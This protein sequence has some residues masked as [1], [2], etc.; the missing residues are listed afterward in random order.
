MNMKHESI[1]DIPLIIEFCKQI[2]LPTLLDNLFPA[3]GNKEGLSDSQLIVGCIA[4]MLTENNHCKSPVQ[5]W[6]KTHKITLEALLGCEIK[7]NDFEDNKLGRFIEKISND[8]LWH[9][10]EKD[11][12]QNSFCVLELDTTAPAE[13]KE[14]PAAEN[15]ISRIIK[16]D[17]TTV[18]GH[19]EIFEDGIMQRGWSKDHRPDLPQ[20]KIMVAV[21]GKTGFQIASDIVPGNENDDPLYLPVLERTRTIVN[22]TNNL[23]CGDCKMSALYIR[24][25]IAKNNE[26]YLTPLQMSNAKIRSEFKDLVNEIVDGNQQAELIYDTHVEKNELTNRIIGAGYE[27]ERGCL[28]SDNED[29]FEWKERLLIVRSFEHAK[30]EIKKFEIKLNNFEKN[31]INLTSKW[32]SSK[33]AAEKDLWSKIDKLKKDDLFD[34]FQLETKLIIEEKIQKR[35]EKRNGKTREGSYKLVKYKYVI[36]SVKVDLEKLSNIKHKLGWRLYVTNAEKKN[37]IFNDAYKYYRKTMYVIEIGFHVIKDTLNINPLFVRGENQIK[38]MTRLLMLALKI[39]TL[40]TATIRAN[41][42]K[43]NFILEG[44]YAGQ[45]KRKHLFPTAQSILSYFSRNNI[46]LIGYEK[47]GKWE[48]CITQLNTTCQKIL[49]LL[50]IPNSYSNLTETLSKFEK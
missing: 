7:E 12:Y 37:L 34:L 21:E 39:L 10:L 45:P 2:N 32:E 48:W 23:I 20:L 3:H 35:S 27:I 14:N 19:H 41:M 13:F 29:V 40:M 16:L 24:A 25:N 50:N 30:S 28:Y 17:S 11:F 15:G 22:T 8:E 5:Q 43:E 33:E 42:K 44:L 26:F 18:S 46:S 9:A 49:A 31:L 6:S 47:D 36:S 1:A 38:G 4:Y